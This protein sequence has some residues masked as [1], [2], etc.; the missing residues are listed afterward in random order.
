MQK[1]L[2]RFLILLSGVAIG[3]IVGLLLPAESRVRLSQP[4]AV[5]IRR[6]VDGIPDG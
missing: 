1:K 3:V 2:V 6:M 5:M 4:L